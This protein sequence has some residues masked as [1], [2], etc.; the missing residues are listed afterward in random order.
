[1]VMSGVSVYPSLERTIRNDVIFSERVG[2]HSI[3]QLLA[4]HEALFAFPG[5]IENQTAVNG[6]G[7]KIRFP[8]QLTELVGSDFAISEGPGV[9][10]VRLHLTFKNGAGTIW[11][12]NFEGGHC[13]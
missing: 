9:G 3:H 13:R 7:N 1:M 5:L 4:V 10:L 11:E 8:Q 2:F 6:H 12:F